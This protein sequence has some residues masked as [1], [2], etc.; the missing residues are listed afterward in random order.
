M[1]GSSG[2]LL[3]FPNHL[4]YGSDSSITVIAGSYS[5]YKSDP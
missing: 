2:Y 5:V 3:G 1:E 4:K